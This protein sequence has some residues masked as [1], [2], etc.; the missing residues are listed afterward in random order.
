MNG[1]TIGE[2]LEDLTGGLL[3]FIALEEYND[4]KKKALFSTLLEYQALGG[5]MGCYI[6]VKLIVIQIW[7]INCH[8]WY[9]ING[10]ASKGGK[11]FQF[12][13]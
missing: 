3:E 4:A 2:A 8:L 11:L 5:L 9:F 12:F 10:E 13:I 1:G 7:N 6:M